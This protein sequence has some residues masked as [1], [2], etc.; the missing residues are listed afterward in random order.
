MK[1]LKKIN[2]FSAA[3]V[4]G[5]LGLINGVLLYIILK[6]T[7]DVSAAAM[8]ATDVLL[9]IFVQGITWFA[10]AFVV[11]LLY[12]LLTKYIG[13]IKLELADHEK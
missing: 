5:I 8:T 4:L 6:L 13:G 3:K 11:A 1:V 10:A 2:A 9:L 7:G 12:N